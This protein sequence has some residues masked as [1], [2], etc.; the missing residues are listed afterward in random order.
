MYRHPFKKNDVSFENIF[1]VSDSVG[2]TDCDESRPV[3]VQ[4]EGSGAPVLAWIQIVL[5]Q[6]GWFFSG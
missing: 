2:V 4:D 1:M 5:N 3:E 6:R